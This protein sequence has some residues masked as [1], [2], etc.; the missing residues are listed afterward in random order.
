[1]A[2]AAIETGS[3]G[4][5]RAK[6]VRAEKPDKLSYVDKAL[7]YAYGVLDGS[8]PA[9]KW[10]KLAC[11]RQLNDLDREARGTFAYRFDRE[12]A[13]RVCRFVELSPHVKG[14][15]FVGRTIHLEDWQCFLL[16]TIFGWISRGSGARRFRRA[17]S[18]IA[19]GNGK[20]AM[21]AAVANYMAFADDEPGAEVYS[22]A[23]TRDQAK[24]VWSAAHAM[25]LG[26]KSYCERAGVRPQAHVIVQ[27]ETNSYFRP[28][29]SDAD[30]AEG[31]NPYF[32]VVDELHAHDRRDLYDNLDTANGKREGSLLW[33]IT[34]GGSDQAGICFEI[35]L[36]VK[37]ILERVIEDD[38]FFGIIYTIDDKDDWTAGPHVWRKANPN[39]GISVDPDDVAKKIESAIETPSKQP[40]TK[41]KHLNVWVN[42]SSAWMD[43][44]RWRKATDPTIKLEGFAGLPCVVSYDLA[45]KLDLLAK[46][47]IFFEDLP[48][49]VKDPETGVFETKL[50]R[51]YWIFGS[52]WT[53]QAALE[54]SSNSQYRGWAIEKRLQICAGETNDYAEVE[55]EVRA[56]CSTYNV[57]EI[58][59]DPF[60]S[61]IMS[62]HLI[63]EGQ[64]VVTVPQQARYLSPAME[65]LE[66]AVYDGRLHHD[67]DPILSW[68]ISNVV[69]KRDKNDNLFP[70]KAR[71]ENKIDPAQALI[72]GLA[73]AL[74]QE[75][76]SGTNTSGCGVYDKCSKCSKFVE[77]R[78]V[79]GKIVFDC[80]GHN[81]QKN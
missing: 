29:S 32:L 15:K 47:R 70:D 80:G 67:G 3:A 43:M 22:A 55:K 17:Y 42:A 77:G 76:F 58:A 37:K 56:D 60:Q 28:L 34:T 79:G 51:H 68:A 63:E 33:S 9:C 38:S 23:T 31:I 12:R 2:T 35:H 59:E 75:S 74:H 71:P 41:T 73:R 19:K 69:A 20:S 18:E 36:Y 10:T 30:S 78:S 8:V 46:M 81:A 54:K 21:I 7:R 5:R 48:T 52:Y 39:W 62:G 1:M 45:S 49:E 72:T 40:S 57:V 64:T 27:P 25:L 11:Q 66:A 65:E 4:E 24:I 26:M 6:R 14:K 53:P 61:W 16:T 13:D 50:K 44:I